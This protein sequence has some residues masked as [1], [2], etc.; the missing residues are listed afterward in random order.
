MIMGIKEV[1]AN[2]QTGWS[3]FVAAL[4]QLFK[5][6]SGKKFLKRREEKMKTR[7]DVIQPATEPVAEMQ[8]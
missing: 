8:A 2:H 7:I 6:E 3:G 5:G 4:I 1:G